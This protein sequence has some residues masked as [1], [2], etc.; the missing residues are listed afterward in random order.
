MKELPE[1]LGKKRRHSS[2]AA[3]GYAN[4]TAFYP[5]TIIRSDGQVEKVPLA[6]EAPKAGEKGRVVSFTRQEEN[7]SASLQ[8][9]IKLAKSLVEDIQG[10]ENG[11][12]LSKSSVFH[13]H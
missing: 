5:I 8:W 1:L 3:S 10:S 9:R 11:M 12:A 2:M 7:D 6:P 4:S 13:C